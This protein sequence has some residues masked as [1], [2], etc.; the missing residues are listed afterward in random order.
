M[1]ER[2]TAFLCA[3]RTCTTHAQVFPI[4]LV[5]GEQ[6]PRDVSTSNLPTAAR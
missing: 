2:R 4:H 6:E 3:P 5:T 1:S